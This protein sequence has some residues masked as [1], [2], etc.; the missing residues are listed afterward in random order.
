MT[1]ERRRHPRREADVPVQL[2]VGDRSLE[3]QLRDVCRDAALV[4]TD[5]PLELNELVELR[6]SLPGLSAS[7]D[8]RG[9]VIRV[10]SGE[11]RLHALAVLF[12]ELPA[13]HATHIDFFVSLYDG[14]SPVPTEAQGAKS[15]P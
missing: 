13:G 9:R 4:E 6:L 15:L 5:Q 12:D 2:T 1:H 14:A 11:A 3:G 8:A 7:L 10:A